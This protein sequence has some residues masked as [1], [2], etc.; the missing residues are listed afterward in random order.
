[1]SRKKRSK[2]KKRSKKI[3]EDVSEIIETVEVHPDAGE[4]SDSDETPA[5]GSPQR[6]DSQR[7]THSNTPIKQKT[8]KDVYFAF[9]PDKYEPLIED[10]LEEYVEWK[11]EKERKKKEKYKKYRKNVGKALRFGWRCLVAGLQSFAGGY[12]TPLSAAATLV[13]DAHR[14]G[15]KG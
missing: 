7:V 2:C 14:A 12:A 4:K 11:E 8:S 13:T 15:S 3:L 10:E 9:L 6:G 5:K 1:M